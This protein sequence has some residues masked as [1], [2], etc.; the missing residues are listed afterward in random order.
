V[1][2]QNIGPASDLRSPVMLH[3]YGIPVSEADG[4][5]LI[6]SLVA[7]GSLDAL[8]AA[9]RVSLGLERD[10]YA[11]ALAPAERDAILVQLEDPPD[12]LAELRGALMRDFEQR[13][14]E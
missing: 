5:A 13:H 12:G 9:G 4:R 2:P 8:S 14:R 10:L 1:Q 6:A 3:L 7:D 11:V